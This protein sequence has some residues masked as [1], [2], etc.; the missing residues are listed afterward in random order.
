MKNQKQSEKTNSGT[1][2][3]TLEEL[4]ERLNNSDLSDDELGSITGAGGGG[5]PGPNQPLGTTQVASKHIRQKRS[6]EVTTDC[7]P[8]L[9]GSAALFS[10]SHAIQ[11]LA[12]SRRRTRLDHRW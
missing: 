11:H 3:V 7:C 10:C 1:S 8:G 5:A 4:Q 9:F 2:A 6:R 12:L